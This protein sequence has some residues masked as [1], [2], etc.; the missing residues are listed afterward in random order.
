MHCALHIMLAVWVLGIFAV[1]ASPHADAASGPWQGGDEV[2]LRLISA[3]GQYDSVK[4]NHA[5]NAGLEVKLAK[6]WKIYWRSPGDAGLPPVLDFS[7]SSAVKGHQMLFPAPERFS[8]FG[9]DT[10]GY[11]EHVIFP[12]TLDIDPDLSSQRQLVIVAGFS[13]LV[14][15]DICI[16]VEETLTMA[17]PVSTI[18]GQAS[19]QP[20]PSDHAFAIAQARSA[21][22]SQATGN[23]Y[24]VQSAQIIGDQLAVTIHDQA[25]AVYSMWQGDILIETDAEGYGFA[26]PQ[27]REGMSHIAITG[28]DAAPLIG[29]MA[30]LTIIHPTFLLEQTIAIETGSASSI[31]TAILPMLVLAFIGGLI[32]NIMPCVLPVLSLKLTSILNQGNANKAQIRRSFLMSAA[33]IILSF[34]VL[35]GGLLGMREAGLAIG[36]GIQFQ[37]PYF[38]AVMAILMIGFALM[39]IDKVMLPVPDFAR[40]W[41]GQLKTG[42]G[43]WH[44]LASGALATILATPCS[45]PFVGTAIA[46]AFTAPSGAMLIIFFAMGGGLAT[47][48]LLVALFPQCAGY[49][50]RPGKWLIYVRYVLAAGLLITA[51]WLGYVLSVVISDS[52]SPLSGDWQ[53]WQPGLAEEYARDGNIVLVDVTA[54]WCLTCKANKFL[55]LDLG[56]VQDYLDAENVI[57]L[58]ADWTKPDDDILTYLSGF[59][60]YGIPFNIIYG[61]DAIDG[62][63]LPELLTVDAVFESIEIADLKTN[64]QK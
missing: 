37:N 3:T 62:I 1:F 41:S 9:L 54:D 7:N 19:D 60:R 24:Q 27:F 33:G 21:V 35:A 39:M 25:G 56:R 34:M 45:A 36:W 12:L 23:G 26:A 61:P 10:F 16:P 46:F 63:I 38:L 43:G 48:W 51:T 14:C 13:G 18:S 44:D 11:G 2:E 17:V 50:P 29:N 31:L 57:L 59:G 6:G 52:Q 53:Q 58:K 49:L 22:P 20:A 42:H 40:R 30:T 8:L 15:A 5:L 32:L 55:V 47:P 64:S 4:T 28:R